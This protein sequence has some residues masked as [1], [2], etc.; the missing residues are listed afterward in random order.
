MCVSGCVLDVV[1]CRSCLRVLFSSPLCWR[2]LFVVRCSLFV[3]CC[4]LFVVCCCLSVSVIDSLIVVCWPFRVSCCC[5][6]LYVVC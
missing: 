6:V 4:L 3:V 2:S 1:C 5:C